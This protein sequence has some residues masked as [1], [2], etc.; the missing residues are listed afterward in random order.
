M[1]LSGQLH[2]WGALLPGKELLVPGVWVG[3]RSV[4]DAVW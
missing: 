1:N 4:L 2:A 3:Q